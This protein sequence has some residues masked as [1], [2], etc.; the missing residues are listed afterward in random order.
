M[1]WGLGGDPIT[2]DRPIWGPPLFAQ[3]SYICSLLAMITFIK[4]LSLDKVLLQF[5]YRFHSLDRKMDEGAR[6]LGLGV[7]LFLLILVWSCTC[8]GL[9][10]FSRLDS[11]QA[12]INCVLSSFPISPECDKVHNYHKNALRKNILSN[13]LNFVI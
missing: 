12:R 7:G 13:K 5:V 11:P 2:A 3:H 10:I 8:A 9:L 6:V 4:K 1:L